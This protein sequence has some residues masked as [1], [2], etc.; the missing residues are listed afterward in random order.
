MILIIAEKPSVAR[1]IKNTLN[2]KENIKWTSETN[3]FQS[4]KY[5]LSWFISGHMFEALLPDRLDPKYKFW[6][7]ED[8]PI[9]PDSL[10]Y[11]YK[12][13][14]LKSH[15]KLLKSLSSKC[16]YII[17][18]CDPDR[19]GEAIF[20]IWFIYE[21]IYKPFKR[22]WAT[23]LAHSDL[24]KSFQNILP[25]KNYDN[26]FFS[27]QSRAYADWLV[28]INATRAISTKLNNK[29]PIGRV[30]T[31]TLVLIVKRDLEIENF[32]KSFTY[33]LKGKWQNKI[34]EFLTDKKDK[35][36]LNEVLKKIKD[37]NFY[38]ESLIKEVKSQNPPKPFSQPELQEI[39]NKRFGFS[40]NKTLEISQHLY[41]KKLMTYPRTDSPYLP[42]AD[43]DNY[44]ILIRKL[45]NP[46][47][48]KILNDKEPSCI[49]NCDSPHTA[50]IPT[51]EA[52]GPIKLSEDENKIMSLIIDRFITAFK[53]PL[54]YN[55]IVL[56]ITNDKYR[57]KCIEK[58]IV[59]SGYTNKDV[60]LGK[61]DYNYLKKIKDKIKDLSI[62]EIENIKP[63]HFTPGTLLKAM[64]NVYYQ[65]SDK[66][67]KDI[68]KEVEGL[69]TAATRHIYPQLLLNSDYIKQ[70][71]QKLIST[72]KGKSLISVVN[73]N[74][75][76][77]ELTAEWELKLKDIGSGCYQKYNFFIEIKKFV[78][79]IIVFDKNILNAFESLSLKCPFC[80]SS[81]KSLNW[82][83]SCDCGFK[84]SKIIA[85]KNI[86]EE[87]AE[88]ILSDGRSKLIKGF[89]NKSGNKFD[90]KL[91]LNKDNRVEFK[92]N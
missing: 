62:L 54:I 51:F 29:L 12:N 39:A 30:Q 92:F 47:D 90:C 77:P 9:I 1:E 36:F 6:K 11:E 25:G 73:E 16:Q 19:E 89:K 50:I 35:I 76:S 5:I 8:L 64:I 74:L 26:L 84:L 40:L 13:N 41:E 42:S 3:Y 82:G 32:K 48:I 78:K 31:A 28:G 18:A 24:Y 55:E 38:L 21:N 37:S 14:Q 52:A 63:N 44:Y 57:F 10:T 70:E 91:I 85:G 4:S 75:S 17:N 49:K 7:Y 46:D 79:D 65:I 33:K 80:N 72:K 81:M 86:S 60:N 23:S 66:K 45:S 71:G 61:F 34:F 2:D 43:K 88:Q 20:R 56:T 15:G 83:W 68:L 58:K 67:R 59:D 53:K 22:L 87:T 27:Q 69:G